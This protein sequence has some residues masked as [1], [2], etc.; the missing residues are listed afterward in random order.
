MGKSVLLENMIVDDILKG[1]GVAVIDPHGDLAEGIIGLIPKNRTN[2]T[3]IF[4]PSDKEWPI[5]FNMLEDVA[6]DQ[7]SFIA[8]GLLALRFVLI[9]LRV[10]YVSVFLITLG[11]TYHTVEHQLDPKDQLR[12]V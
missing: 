1:R 2:Q 8:S 5:A 6:E 11:Q 4:D 7:R 12:L 10:F 9:F 3:I